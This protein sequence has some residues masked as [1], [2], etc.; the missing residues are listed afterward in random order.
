MGVLLVGGTVTLVVLLVQRAGVA[1]R[2]GD[3]ALGQPE[4]ARIAGIA[5]GADG[6]LAVWVARPDGDRVLLVDTRRGAT[7]G[8][9][10]LR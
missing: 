3:V 4:G 1:A 2:V 8:E 10:R 9:V 6:V 5:Q 7:A